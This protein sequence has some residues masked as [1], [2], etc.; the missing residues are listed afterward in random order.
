MTP[1]QPVYSYS[2][3]WI[4]SFAGILTVLYPTGLYDSGI[5]GSTPKFVGYSFVSFLWLDSSLIFCTLYLGADQLLCHRKN[6][7]SLH[8]KVRQ[9]DSLSYTRLFLEIILVV[10]SHSFECRKLLWVVMP[11]KYDLVFCFVCFVI[12]FA[13]H[14]KIRIM[15]N[16]IQSKYCS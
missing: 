6:M 12:G 7:I 2:G 15:G 8:L 13:L 9:Y 14:I 4:C 1:N 16:K 3:Q 11:F 10:L 5:W